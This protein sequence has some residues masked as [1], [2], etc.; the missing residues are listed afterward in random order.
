ME[1]IPIRIHEDTKE[2]LE[3]EAADQNISVSAYT[4]EL[5]EKGREFDAEEH[6]DVLEKY[7]ASGE[8]GEEVSQLRAIT[9]RVEPSTE[10]TLEAETADNDVSLSEHIRDLIARGRA[11]E[12][13]VAKEAEPEQ[14]EVPDEDNTENEEDVWAE[15]DHQNDQSKMGEVSIELTVT[16]ETNTWLQEQ[17]ADS[18]LSVAGYVEELLETARESETEGANVDD[19]VAQEAIDD[20][21]T[22]RVGRIEA[23][24][25]ALDERQTDTVEGLSELKQR[26]ATIEAQ[27][28]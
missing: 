1:P 25:E 28:E 11:Q 12:Y 4:R 17:T 2:A 23:E 13:I 22:D 21:L 9:L 18:E 24:L 8:N 26:V 14:S 16:P 10:E 5:I 15:S 19:R 6:E 7:S 3:Y 27:I 20:S